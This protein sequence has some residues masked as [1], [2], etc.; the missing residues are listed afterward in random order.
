M[1]QLLNCKHQV[2]CFLEELNKL[3]CKL[4]LVCPNLCHCHQFQ[5]HPKDQCP[6]NK[7]CSE[8]LNQ[9]L[10]LLHRHFQ[11]CQVH[12][13]QQQHQQQLYFLQLQL[14]VYQLTKHSD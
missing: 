14:E 10:K 8:C 7:F 3:F 5:I 2:Q 12:C 13:F 9:A 4:Y 6:L 11:V 1:L